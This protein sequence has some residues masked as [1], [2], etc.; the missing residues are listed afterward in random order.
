M[1]ARPALI[2]S[3]DQFVTAIA[4]HEAV[5]RE[6]YMLP[7]S[8]ALQGLLA[9][10]QT[11]YA[12]AAE[13]GMPMPRTEYA[14]GEEQVVQFAKDARKLLAYKRDLGGRIQCRGK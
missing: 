6:H 7:P 8:A 10:K 4:A 3:S 13:H 5:L 9:D 12:L 11:Q 2:S 14:T 1:P